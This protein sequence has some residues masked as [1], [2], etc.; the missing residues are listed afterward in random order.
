MQR[1]FIDLHTDTASAILDE[2]KALRKNDLHVDLERMRAVGEYHPFL[3]LFTDSSKRDMT[4]RYEE[5]SENLLREARREVRFVTSGEELE[6]AK[7][8]GLFPAFRAVEGA[9][10]LLC[11]PEKMR[12]AA[13]EE[14]LLMSGITWNNPNPLWQE[15]GLTEKGRIYVRACVDEGVAVDV[16]HL[17]DAGTREILSMGIPAVA[18][19]SDARA[20]CPVWRN[21]PDD[22]IRRIGE[23]R[24]LIGM[25]F[26]AHF[27]DADPREQTLRRLAEHAAHIAEVAGA[28]VLAL[29]SDFDGAPMPRGVAGVQ[30]LP[31]FAE[32]LSR[33]GFSPKEIDDVCYGNAY[34]YFFVERKDKRL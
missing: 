25:N 8:D 31:L 9:E 4:G 18:S 30:D 23:N 28:G 32:E 19:H 13:R 17:N 21:L 33:A 12:K 5:L 29:G 10:I 11:D 6:K 14:K 1:R 15:D 20:L 16:S 26:C 34:R 24:G 27:I 22:L 2:K 3:T 7:K